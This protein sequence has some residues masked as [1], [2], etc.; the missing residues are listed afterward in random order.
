MV[1]LS[2][3]KFDHSVFPADSLLHSKFVT[4]THLYLAVFP[5]NICA[6]F[7]MQM[8]N[9]NIGDKFNFTSFGFGKAK[10]VEIDPAE[11]ILWVE[12]VQ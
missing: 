1:D 5:D 4:D 10:V 11:K 3:Y 6:A 7:V 2:K 9:I 8:T 12:K